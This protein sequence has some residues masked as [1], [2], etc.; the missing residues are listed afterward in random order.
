MSK[1]QWV[2]LTGFR[3][4]SCQDF[5]SIEEFFSPITL[6]LGWNGSGKST[7]LEV[8]K[9]LICGSYPPSTGNGW[10]FIWDPGISNQSEMKACAKLLFKTVGG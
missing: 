7:I 10:S 4:Y 5:E 1:L 2:F 6:I 3:S 9:F 8:L